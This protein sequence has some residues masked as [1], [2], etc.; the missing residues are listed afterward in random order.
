L[1]R[2]HEEGADV[3]SSIMERTDRQTEDELFT[4]D[5]SDAWLEA[6]ALGQELG[7]AYTEFAYCTQ[8]LCP[9]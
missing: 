6:T 7:G 5:V 9:G 3:M 2:N 1:S 4:A 8:V